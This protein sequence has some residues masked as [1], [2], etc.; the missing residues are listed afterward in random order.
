MARAVASVQRRPNA[1]HKVVA[2][3]WLEKKSE[4]AAF[5]CLR[6]NGGIVLTGQHDHASLG[7]DAADPF[8]HFES[9]HRGHPDVDYR[10]ARLILMGVMQERVR[11]TE[12]FYLETSGA[13][14]APG[15]LQDGEIVIEQANSRGGYR[16]IRLATRGAF[17]SAVFS[18]SRKHLVKAKTLANQSGARG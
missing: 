11:V 9:I 17:C 1:L 7:R 18:Y 8:L 15:R 12:G 6:L 4:R 10:H 2:G 13:D 3:H 16:G 5:N 14:E